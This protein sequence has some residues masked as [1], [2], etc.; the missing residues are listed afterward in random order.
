MI[1]YLAGWTRRKDAIFRAIAAAA[2]G[3]HRLALIGLSFRG[4]PETRARTAEALAVAK[5]QP[6]GRLGRVLKRALIA[7]QYNWSRRYFARHPDRIAVCWNGL[8]GSRRA[9]M[10]GARDAGAGRIFAELAPFPGRVTL[11]PVGVNARNGV[12]REP[13]FYLDWAAED[14]SRQGEDWRA[15]GQGLVARAS[16]RA[17]VGQGGAG[18]L[19]GAG[20][21]LFCPLQVPNDSQ[22]TLFAGWVRSVEGMIA[23]LARASAALPEGWHIRIKEHPSARTSLAAPLAEAMAQAGGRLMIDNATDSFAQLAASRGVIT[24]NS[25][26]GLQAF[27]HDKPVIVLGEAFFAI[28][29]LTVPARDE[30]ALAAALRAPADLGF[31]PALRAAFMTYLDRVYYPKIEEGPDGVRID[32]G[33][34]ARV[35]A[36]ARP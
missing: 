20:P 3:G 36:A 12:P 18:A 21:F 29:G 10:E 17:D 2:G 31:D 1:A 19:D 22:I 33:A 11:D 30:A 14:P 6:K 8:T 26:M 7:A 24:I 35:L 28:P 32:P 16:R 34:L 4:F 9:F 13:R 15:L 23:A 27:F 5:R 25:S